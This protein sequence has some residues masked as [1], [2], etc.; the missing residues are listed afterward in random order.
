MTKLGWFKY[1][2]SMKTLKSSTIFARRKIW[3]K[4][5]KCLFNDHKL[6]WNYA[7]ISLLE[8][9]LLFMK[10]YLMIFLFRLFQ[11]WDAEAITIV[12][13][14]RPVATRNVLIPVE[15]KSVA[16]VRE[17][18]RLDINA[19]ALTVSNHYFSNLIIETPAPMDPLSL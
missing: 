13:T 7:T 12:R 14:N 5:L 3:N 17:R 8:P 15:P 11:S 6:N 19:N 1:Q 9:P 18:N 10:N 4:K 2:K 16:E